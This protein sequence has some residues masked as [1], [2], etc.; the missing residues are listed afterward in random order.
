MALL[1]VRV[2]VPPVRV[3]LLLV[4]KA[5]VWETLGLTVSPPA[6]DITPV[7]L[8]GL[9]PVNARLPVEPSPEKVLYTNAP[10][11]VLM[12]IGLPVVI[13]AAEPDWIVPP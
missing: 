13:P 5:K 12:A 3:L 1:N 10:V 4:P 9:G 8:K 11:P 6:P 2:N 7:R